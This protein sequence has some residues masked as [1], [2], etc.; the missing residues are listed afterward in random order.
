MAGIAGFVSAVPRSL[1]AR[2]GDLT[3]PLVFQPGNRVESW[4][5]DRA[6]MCAVGTGSGR[7]ET[8]PIFNQARTKCIVFFGECFDHD[9]QKR[10]LIHRGRAFAHA[11]SDAEFCLSLYEEHGQDAFARLDGSYCFAILDVTR[12]EVVLVADRMGTR[13]LFYGLTPDGSL[14]F[15][16]QVSAVLSEPGIDRQL[17]QSAVIEFCCLQRVLGS[18]TFHRGVSTLAPASALR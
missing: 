3:R 11:D 1:A 14:V 4:H 15:A 2:I 18:K 13:P 17:D 6:A 10:E 9:G 5:N 16:T 7:T 12:S 8:Q